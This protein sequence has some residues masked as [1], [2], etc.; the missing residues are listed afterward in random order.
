MV[1]IINIERHMHNRSCFDVCVPRVLFQ[2]ATC[3]LNWFEE[4]CKA[5]T[6]KEV[7]VLLVTK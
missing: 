6:I 3:S 1:V 4:L 2:I 5:T 7:V